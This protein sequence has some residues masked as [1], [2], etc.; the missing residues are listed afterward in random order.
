[1]F[2]TVPTTFEDSF[3][4]GLASLNKRYPDNQ[5]YE[6][7]GSLPLSILGSAR[8]A[9][10]LPMVDIDGLKRHVALAHELGIKF[11]YLVNAP[12]LH[13]QE[14]TYEGQ[15]EIKAYLDEVVS[16]GVDSFT[17]TIPYLMEI[18]ER[19]YPRLEVVASTICYIDS[20]QK[21]IKYR[22][23]GADR[24][25]V[26]VEVNRHLHL[27]E[28]MGKASD[29][30]LEVIVN[31]YCIL[32]CPYKYYHYTCASHG[33]QSTVDNEGKGSMYNE[34]NLLRCTLDKL[35][36][37]AEFIKSPWIRPEDLRYLR[38]AGVEYI[39]VAGRGS[40]GTDQLK[41]IEAYMAEW[42]EG[43]LVPLVGWPHWQSFRTLP[44]G[45]RMEKLEFYVD[46]R[47][48]DGMMEF[49][50]RKD[51]LCLEGCGDCNYCHRLA[52]RMVKCD[53][54]LEARYIE[55]MKGRLD[56][57]TR[58]EMGPETAATAHEK[59]VKLVEKQK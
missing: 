18:I 43:N 22:Q 8:P 48:L 54:E 37:H 56:T 42:F 45:A 7:Y 13:N 21:A 23:M 47:S 27:L 58:Y 10:Y 6:V 40:P 59:W 1:M 33:S 31:P 46:N 34:Y 55:N 32:S 39:K 29:I 38:E 52:D 26:D 17:V 5:V 20:V 9:K 25:V 15:E 14:Y 2:I 3:L 28:R 44:D 19:R 53:S 41:V 24:L 57:I 49:F 30:P 11:N 4:R 51:I 35:T 50:K 16:C 36:D 12:S